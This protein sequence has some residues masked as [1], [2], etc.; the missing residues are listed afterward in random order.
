MYWNKHSGLEGLPWRG[1][2]LCILC[3]WYVAYHSC[4]I[5]RFVT[6]SFITFSSYPQKL[7]PSLCPQY[8]LEDLGILSLQDNSLRLMGTF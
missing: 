8:S 6:F 2:C 3:I 1:E 4:Y 5:I 7:E